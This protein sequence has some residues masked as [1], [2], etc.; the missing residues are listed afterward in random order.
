[1]QLQPFTLGHALLL[2]RLGSPLIAVEGVSE[3]PAIGFGDVLVGAWICSRTARQAIVDLDSHWQMLW[4]RW[5]RLTRA[6]FMAA[7]QLAL[8]K[9]INAAYQAPPIKVLQQGEGEG[10]GAPWLAILFVT[11]VGHCGYTAEKALDTPLATAQWLHALRLEE[12]GVLRIE[13]LEDQAFA[14]AAEEQR[15]K[16]LEDPAAMLALVNQIS[17]NPS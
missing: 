13:S 1:V 12:T 2:T 6:S 15:R 7:D 8:L 16:A 4:L 10:R 5:K 17:G 3:L 9:Y 11:L 14:A